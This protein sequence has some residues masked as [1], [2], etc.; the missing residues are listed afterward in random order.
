MKRTISRGLPVLVAGL[1][2]AGAA[3]V[4]SPASAAAAQYQA[5]LGFTITRGDSV[6]LLMNDVYTCHTDFRVGVRKEI[7]V[8]VNPGQGIHVFNSDGCY[9]SLEMSDV[10]IT[11]DGQRTDF[12]L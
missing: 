9:N 12:I 6:Y 4:V 1:A 5:V 11:S 8:K 3:A 10:T 7:H 2:I